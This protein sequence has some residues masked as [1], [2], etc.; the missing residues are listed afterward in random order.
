MLKDKFKH[1]IKLTNIDGSGKA[2]SYVRAL[3]LLSEM[4]LVESFGMHDCKAIWNVSSIE[5]LSQ[6]YEV[7][8]VEKRKSDSSIWNIDGLPKSYLQNGFCS[9]ALKSFMEFI[10]ENS[11][12]QNLLD[13]FEHHDSD[14]A[15]LPK[16][17]EIDINY[18]K[19]LI[20][21]LDK[22]QGEDV[23]R[24][25][26]V[27]S[28]Q[29]VFRKMILKIYNQSCCITGLNIP[30]VNRASHIIPWAKDVSKRLDPRN[31]LCLSATY[32]AAFDRNLISLD[33]DYRIIISK[34]IRDFYMNDSVKEYFMNKEGRKITLPHSY[35]PDKE[36]LSEHRKIGN[37]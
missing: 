25:V 13:I 22:M 18:P 23:V 4:L 14:E 19:L 3:D 7:V 28:N 2:S 31:G 11:Y 12:E 24:K 8:L 1:F 21:G 26:R 9:A 33:D 35:L 32:D 37:F 29:N 27:R 20:E 10:V 15:L 30:A 5:R 16:K 34:D 17:L 36:Y 6:L